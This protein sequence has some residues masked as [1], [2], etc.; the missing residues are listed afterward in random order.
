MKITRENS[1]KQFKQ[2][3]FADSPRSLSN[4]IPKWEMQKPCQIIS[5]ILVC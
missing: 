4:D 1:F 3:W 5:S 2:L